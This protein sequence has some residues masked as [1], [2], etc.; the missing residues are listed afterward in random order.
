M[1]AELFK[2]TGKKKGMKLA[3]NIL[4]SGQAYEKMKEIIKLQGGN[5]NIKPEEIPLARFEYDYVAEK[6]G[7]I[8]SIN[9][10]MIAKLARIAGAPQNKGAGIYLYRHVGDKLEKGKRILTV[11]ADSKHKIEY[12]KQT[13][14]N[15]DA[16]VEY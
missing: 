1:C 10:I 15:M 13:L 7:K 14:R 11:Y 5:P 2:M 4:Q 3:K 12:V 6:N 9:N 8:K 16:I